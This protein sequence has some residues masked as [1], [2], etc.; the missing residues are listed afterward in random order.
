[1]KESKILAG[2]AETSKKKF[3]PTKSD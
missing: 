1:M 3:L 2:F